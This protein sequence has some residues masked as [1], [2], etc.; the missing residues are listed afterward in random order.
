MSVSHWE[1]GGELG[2][3]AKASGESLR[4]P[5]VIQALQSSPPREGWWRCR[6]AVGRLADAGARGRWQPGWHKAGGSPCAERA[7]SAGGSRYTQT[8][9]Q[10]L[11][12]QRH[13]QSPTNTFIISSAC[14]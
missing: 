9:T 13:L 8:A 2:G 3:T 14:F 7:G 10:S 4:W 1:R 5:L 6:W 11:L 12:P